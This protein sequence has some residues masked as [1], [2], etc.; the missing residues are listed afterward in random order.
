MAQA[1]G[2]RDILPRLYAL[3][4]QYGGVQVAD[5]AIWCTNRVD[6]LLNTADHSEATGRELQVGYGELAEMSGWLSFD[7]WLLDQAQ[8]FCPHPR[9]LRRPGSASRSGKA[10]RY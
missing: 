3:D 10:E 5:L 8:T 4:D 9:R 2:V 7:A 1:T 6:H